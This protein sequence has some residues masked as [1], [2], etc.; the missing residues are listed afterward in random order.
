M[1]IDIRF[2]LD[3]SGFLCRFDQLNTFCGPA[4][5]RR[6]A[7][8][9]AHEPCR[10]VREFGD[11]IPTYHAAVLNTA[12]IP[13]IIEIEL[14]TTGISR[15]YQLIKVYGSFSDIAYLH[16]LLFYEIAQFIV[17]EVFG[18]E[19]ANDVSDVR[20]LDLLA[21]LAD[22]KAVRHHAREE[23]GLPNPVDVAWQPDYSGIRDVA[24]I[25]DRGEHGNCGVFRSG[26]I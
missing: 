25:L 17:V 11:R 19:Q 1:E 13:Q 20:N 4:H 18:A 21:V 8:A 14:V 23:L 10:D 16:A 15:Y 12:R 22:F 7:L 5:E 2:C 9:R 26:R 6:P 3:I 24:R